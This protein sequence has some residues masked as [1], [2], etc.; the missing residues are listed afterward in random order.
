MS[1][2][3]TNEQGKAIKF[4]EGDVSL[5][6][7]M[8][9]GS[10]FPSAIPIIDR[11]VHLLDGTTISQEGTYEN[12]AILIKA[13]ISAGYNIT[14]TQEEF[15]TSVSTYGQCG[16]FVVDNDAKTIR[17]PLITEFIASN[18]GGQEI[19][20]AQL[21][22]FKS[23]THLGLMADDV[24]GNSNAAKMA[25]NN[26]IN[27]QTMSYTG[28]D[29][30]RPKNIRYPYYIVLASGF[31]TNAD[32]IIDPFIDDVEKIKSKYVKSATVEDDILKIT[33]QNNNI[34]EFQGG[35]GSSENCVSTNTEQE[36]SAYKNFLEGIGISDSFNLKKLE[37]TT[38][39]PHID[40]RNLKDGIYFLPRNT[41]VYIQTNGVTSLGEGFYIVSTKTN[42]GTGKYWF[43][44]GERSG[45]PT[46]MKGYLTTSGGSYEEV[47]TS[48]FI[49]TGETYTQNISC[50]YSGEKSILSLTGH[51]T[52]GTFLD[53]VNFEDGIGKT[54]SIGIN[55]EFK[56]VF[57][58]KDGVESE[59]GGGGS[60]NIIW[61]EWS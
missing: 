51:S 42:G 12:F 7:S 26:Y 5:Q 48:G 44:F 53:F 49:K 11:R 38:E 30:T 56:P 35:G 24:A 28:G 32:I 15:D 29:E 22:E 52:E 25:Y 43:Y 4:A 13:L 19:G 10:I 40:P 50:N 17:L 59:L 21:D 18:N 20:L 1:G 55:E 33:D 57:I 60:A 58:D 47:K 37:S 8:P 36:I 23:H 2:F 6:A 16:K 27:R 14:C 54:C 45:Q 46:I 3:Y 9:V 31:K 61:K 34:I 39:T 41:S